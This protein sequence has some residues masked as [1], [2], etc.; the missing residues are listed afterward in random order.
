[1]FRQEASVENMKMKTK[2][3]RNLIIGKNSEK[4]GELKYKT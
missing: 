1:M 3:Q 4:S 2:I